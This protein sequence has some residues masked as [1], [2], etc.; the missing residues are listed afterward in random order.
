MY[1]LSVGAVFKNESTILKEWLDHYLHHGV[2]HF[3]LIN[4]DSTDAFM[5]VLSPYIDKQLVTLS[6]VHGWTYYT[7][8]Q[9]DLYN[10]FIL[11]HIK[12]TNWLLIVDLDEYLWSPQHVD[13]NCILDQCNHYAQIQVTDVLFGS[14]GHVEQPSSIVKSFTMR[15]LKPR[16][17]YKYFVNSQFE[18]DSLNV[19]HGGAVNPIHMTPTYFVILQQEWFILNH[20]S[21]LSRQYWEQIKC[22]RGDCD[23]YCVRTKEMF[24]LLDV[25]ETE[26]LRLLKQNYPD[27]T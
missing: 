19:H 8:R 3:Y 17:H 22:V 24:T 7:S 10:S 13:L 27:T 21:C 16:C 6:H 26:D 25:N 15:Q 20:Y 5:D 2:E 12:E 4:D 11:S 9:R 1:K 23:N 14:N 18:F